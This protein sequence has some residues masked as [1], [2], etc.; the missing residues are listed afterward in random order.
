MDIPSAIRSAAPNAPAAAIEGF[1]TARSALEQAG[2]LANANRAAH[3]IG[4]CAHESGGFRRL[5]ESLHYTTARRLMDVWPTRFRSLGAAEPFVRNAE[6]LANIVYANRNG[7]GSPA[8]GDGFRYRGRGYL[9]LT[10]RAN[11]SEFGPL[12]GVD[13]VANPDRATEPAIAWLIAG[14][15]LAR[16]SRHGRTALEWADQGSVESVTRIVNGGVNGLADRRELTMHA[17]AALGGATFRRQLGRGDEGPAVERLQTLLAARG[18]PPGAIDGDFGKK[19]E[20]ALKGFQAGA[21]LLESGVADTAV[22][23]ALDPASA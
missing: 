20:A 23:E 12:V 18:F 2:V 19:T 1:E 5:V 22:W 21:G 11:Y 7:N 10:G 9:Q 3:L 14:H 6:G 13:L 16:R 17:L 15:F 8:S 4:Q